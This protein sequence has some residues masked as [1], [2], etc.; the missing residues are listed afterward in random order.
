[1]T[2]SGAVKG[3][4]S[5]RGVTP[6]PSVAVWMIDE[7]RDNEFRKGVIKAMPEKVMN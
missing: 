5:L 3:A 7:N 6:R 4:N 1:M 2:G